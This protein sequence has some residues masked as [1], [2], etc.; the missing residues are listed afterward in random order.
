MLGADARFRRIYFN[1]HADPLGIGKSPSRF[2]DPRRRVP[3]HRYGVLYLGESLKVCFLEAILRDTRNGAVGDYPMEEREILARNVAEI[4]VVTP[5]SLADLR[6]DSPIRMGIPSDVARASRQGL[7][8]RWSLAFHEHPSAP[9]GIIYASRLNGETNIA[10]YDR[11][12]PKLRVSSVGRL[13]DAA[14]LPDV[15]DDLQV[16]IV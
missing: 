14:E 13:I 7:A 3:E 1:R 16:A 12:I 6:G 15:L 9:D 5:L 2:S 4:E 8:R 11:A 10:V